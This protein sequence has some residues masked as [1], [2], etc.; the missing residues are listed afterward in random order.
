MG[1]I[2]DIVLIKNL[3]N[4]PQ[5]EV[6]KE[7]SSDHLPINFE[8]YAFYSPL[9][10]ACTKINCTHFT[11]RLNNV[12]SRAT[13]ERISDTENEISKLNFRIQNAIE[14]DVENAGK[15]HITQTRK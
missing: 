5:L 14:T 11:E 7:L 1:D 15:S 3:P 10:K 9:P 13:F 6:I 12:P 4:V 8:F 2:L